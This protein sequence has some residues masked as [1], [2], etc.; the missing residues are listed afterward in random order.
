MNK[1]IRD[2]YP[3]SKLPEDLRQGLPL[4]GE[5][6]IVVE[7]RPKRRGYTLQELLELKQSIAP[8]TDNPVER[9]RALR[10][11]WD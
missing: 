6:R 8:A 7:S 11:E 9:I 4:D 5:A 10:D 3:V 2:H 1:I